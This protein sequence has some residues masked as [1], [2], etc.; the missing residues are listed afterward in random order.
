[1]NMGKKITLLIAAGLTVAGIAFV[2]VFGAKLDDGLRSLEVDPAE[3]RTF[4]A[5]EP[6]RAFS[7]ENGTDTV[8]LS[9]SA[10]GKCTVTCA[11]RTRLTHTVTVEDGT[12]T[13]RQTDRRTWYDHLIPFFHDETIEICIPAGRYASFVVADSTGS[14]IVPS[15]FSF[16]TATIESDTGDVN[17]AAAVEKTLDVTTQTG[18][19]ALSAV[20]LKDALHL[21][22]DTGDIRVRNVQTQS[23]AMV[24]TQTGDVFLADMTCRAMDVQ[25]DTGEI[26]LQ[27]AVAS[28][29]LQVESETGDI[30]LD[31]CDAAELS[32][33]SD[34]GDVTGSVRTEKV[35]QASSDTGT[36]R[37]PDSIRGGR[38]K[39]ITDT[40]DIVMQIE[41]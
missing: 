11:E 33:Q 27:N 18:N 6:I 26:T 2:G 32:L 10:D 38:C 25:S 35:F 39:I 5:D 14:V 9:P 17:F 36:I 37:V 13:V 15:D 23:D 3:S 16:G 1:M 22:T 8:S 28:G 41:Q 4:T 40:G 19:I 31:R 30:S 24:C 34:T 7:I 12:L 20:L 21:A 29:M